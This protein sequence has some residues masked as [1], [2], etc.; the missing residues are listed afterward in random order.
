M[1]SWFKVYSIKGFWKVWSMSGH[2][3]SAESSMLLEE[4]GLWKGFPH[5]YYFTHRG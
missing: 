4:L 3:E 2:A 1:L 5:S